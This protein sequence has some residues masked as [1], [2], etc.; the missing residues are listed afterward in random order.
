MLNEGEVRRQDRFCLWGEFGLI[1]SCSSVRFGASRTLYLWGGLSSDSQLDVLIFWCLIVLA[2]LGQNG[3]ST[4]DNDRFPF[5][6]ELDNQAS[7]ETCVMLPASQK[8][9]KP[10]KI[11]FSHWKR[12]D[13]RFSLMQ[14]KIK[15]LKKSSSLPD[16]TFLLNLF[17][18]I[19]KFTFRYYRFSTW[20]PT[21]G[22]H[23]MYLL[24]VSIFFLC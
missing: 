18:M 23:R 19:S 21:C 20:S 11:M 10:S 13:P 8:T 5:Y 9:S 12:T 17:L 1:W 14:I 3:A 4:A 22:L 6:D 2:A 15:V 24:I 7:S 16:R